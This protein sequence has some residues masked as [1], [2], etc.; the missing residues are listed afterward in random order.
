MKGFDR[1]VDHGILFLLFLRQE[2]STK[3]VIYKKPFPVNYMCLIC[4]LS[5]ILC[6]FLQRISLFSLLIK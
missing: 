2:T 5:F 6:S 4:H 1:F 3:Q